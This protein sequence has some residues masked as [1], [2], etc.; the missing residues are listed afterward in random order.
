M[1]QDEL[2]AAL[3][4]LDMMDMGDNQQGTEEQSSQPQE[5]GLGMFSN[6]PL[7]VT[8][9]VATTEVSMGELSKASIGDVLGLDKAVNE[10]LDVKVNGMPF[11][12]AEVVTVDGKYALKFV[13]GI[14]K[15]AET[16]QIDI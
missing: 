6:V 4:E 13:S 1:T 16:T 5:R 2:Q 10:P 9:E 14:S 12:K 8:L 3:G 11:A 15:P 7:T